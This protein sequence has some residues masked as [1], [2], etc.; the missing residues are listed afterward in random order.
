MIELAGN[1][2]FLRPWWLVLLPLGVV[3]VYFVNQRAGG[4]WQQICDSTLLPHLLVGGKGTSHLLSRMAILFGWI[5]GVIALAGPAWDKQDTPLY[6][7]VDAMVLV[8]DLSYSM[9]AADIAPTRLE[10]AKFK[11][12]ETIEKNPGVAVGLIVFAGDAFNVAPVSDDAAT[13]I[14]LLRTLSTDIVPL[15]GSRAGPALTRAINLLDGSGVKSGTILLFTDGVSDSK[16]EAKQVADSGYQLN[17]VGVGTDEGA[18]VPT[19]DGTFLSDDAGNV[20]LS[21][22]ER[23]QLQDLAS[24]ANG[25]FYL[26][27]AQEV[28]LKVADLGF[29]GDEQLDFGHHDVSTTRWNDRGAWLA[30]LLIPLAALMF[31]RGWL[32]ALCLYVP[33]TTHDAHAFD[34]QGFF[35]RADQRT[36]EAIESGDYRT[37]VNIAPDATWRGVAHYRAGDFPQAT[38]SFEQL[39]GTAEAHYN[40]GNALAKSGHLHQAVEQYD[41]AIELSPD[42]EDAIFNRDL[43]LSLLE[44]ISMSRGDG[45]GQQG[46]QSDQLNDTPGDSGS[47]EGQFGRTLDDPMAETTEQNS[48]DSD[49]ASEQSDAE[50]APTTI[51]GL[52]S[53]DDSTDQDDSAGGDRSISVQ[54]AEQ[55]QIMEQWLRKVPDDPSG[56]LRRKFLYQSRVRAL[57][58]GG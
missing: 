57:N 6:K 12:I 10:R 42:F 35:K 53:D 16:S 51:S 4:S 54:R 26:L 13:V 43:L 11:A 50:D 31:R 49:R 2:V 20:L 34:W 25:R 55:A 44:Q 3:L 23:D 47:E 1:F 21:R 5:L 27:T 8:M 56:L 36:S 58:K 14:H 15:Q 48:A 45:D 9:N 33:F 29:F 41:A 37:A 22:L 40:Y 30:L 28:S 24:A 19:P 52:Q 7:S 39:D 18:V 32:F 38:K 46:D 17:V